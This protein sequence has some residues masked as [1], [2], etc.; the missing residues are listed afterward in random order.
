M[1]EIVLV[2][3]HRREATLRRGSVEVGGGGLRGISPLHGF[4]FILGKIGTFSEPF[5][6]KFCVYFLD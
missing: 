4:F 6:S 5:F 3:E 1:A 2:S